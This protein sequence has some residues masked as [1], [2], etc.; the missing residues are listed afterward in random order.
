MYIILFNINKIPVRNAEAIKKQPMGRDNDV[1]CNNIKIIYEIERKKC[2]RM[3]QKEKR[4]L[5]N[6]IQ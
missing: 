5:L 3:I 6:N 4:N 1:K 2:K